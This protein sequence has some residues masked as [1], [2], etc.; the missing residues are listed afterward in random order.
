MYC[1][2]ISRDFQRAERQQEIV[3]LDTGVNI[4]TI[5]ESAWIILDANPS[6]GYSWRPT[7]DNSETYKVIKNFYLPSNIGAVGTPGKA[8]WILKAVNTGQGS[9]ILTYTRPYAEDPNDKKIIYNINV[10]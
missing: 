5:G 8:I 4:M 7:L 10:M 6:T 2:Y 3:L 9:I 1:P